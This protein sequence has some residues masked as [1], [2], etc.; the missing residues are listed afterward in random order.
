MEKGAS[1][2][3]FFRAISIFA[4]F[5]FVVLMGSAGDAISKEMCPWVPS[6]ALVKQIEAG[7]TMPKALAL[8][9]YRRYYSGDLFKGRRI[10]VAVFLESDHPGTE[11]VPQ[12]KLPRILDGGCSVVNLRYDIKLKKMLVI[13]CNG[14]G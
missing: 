3:V 11:I 5:F 9:S 13:A 2:D 10:V 4:S 12:S 14:V 1:K 6:S 8:H 7:L